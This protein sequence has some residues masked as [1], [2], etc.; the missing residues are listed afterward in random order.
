MSGGKTSGWRALA[1]LATHSV[2]GLAVFAILAIPAV[3]LHLAIHWL[4][5][6]NYASKG[7]L[8]VFKVVE[9]A[10][11]LADAALYLYLVGKSLYK[12]AEDIEL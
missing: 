1:R 8:F 5:V 12:A 10:Y 6:N 11:V 4:D 7:L 3:L 2:L 9:Y